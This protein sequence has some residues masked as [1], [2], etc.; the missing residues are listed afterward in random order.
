[1]RFKVHTVKELYLNLNKYYDNREEG[2]C[3]PLYIQPLLLSGS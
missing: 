2:A 1:M 3:F